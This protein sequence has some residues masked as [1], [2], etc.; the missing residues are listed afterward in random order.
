MKFHC[1]CIGKISNEFENVLHIKV[2]RYF[3]QIWY[4]NISVYIK[5][6]NI[7]DLIEYRDLSIVAV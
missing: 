1:D 3:L 7:K 6:I 4:I 5:Y 2:T